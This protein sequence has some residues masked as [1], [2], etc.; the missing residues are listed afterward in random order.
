MNPWFWTNSKKRETEKAIKHDD[1][2]IASTLTYEPLAIDESK[3]C[4]IRTAEQ[5]E[6]EHECT[7]TSK[8][9]R[10][11]IT[12]MRRLGKGD[13][14]ANI[15][16]CNG[17]TLEVRTTTLYKGENRS[18][19]DLGQWCSTK[20]GK[21]VSNLGE[22][23]SYM[24]TCEAVLCEWKH[25]DNERLTKNDE[26]K[27]LIGPRYPLEHRLRLPQHVEDRIQQLWRIEDGWING[28]GMKPSSSA[29]TRLRAVLSGLNKTHQE[30]AHLY[31]TPEGSIQAEW[32]GRTDGLDAVFADNGSVGFSHGEKE[33]DFTSDTSS[34]IIASRLNEALDK[35]T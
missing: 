35:L 5:H 11:V 23:L 13:F 29:L 32:T 26:G 1:T 6:P 20:D 31:P 19:R 24:L 17:T 22:N 12:D 9:T 8:S 21:A 34:Q 7:I 10:S 30:N 28:T 25:I 14:V 16:F 3:P 33:V 27:K 18:S 2:T 15:T 4:V